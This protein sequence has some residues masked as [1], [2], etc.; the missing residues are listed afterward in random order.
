MNRKAKLKKLWPFTDCISKI[1][2]MQVG[3]AKY[4]GAV[5]LMYNLIE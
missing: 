1:S 5:K 4:L 2:N 3:N